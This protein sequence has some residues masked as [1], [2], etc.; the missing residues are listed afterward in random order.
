[1]ALAPNIEAISSSRT[2]PVTR[3]ARVSRETVEA[4]LK[5]LTGPSVAQRAFATDRSIASGADSGSAAAKP[6]RMEALL[7]SSSDTRKYIKW[8]LR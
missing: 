3:E 2:S 6:D 1:M 7:A 4:A 8:H 5:R